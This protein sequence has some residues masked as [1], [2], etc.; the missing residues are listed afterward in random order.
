MADLL[1]SIPDTSA[2]ED[3]EP[4][5]VGLE[6]DD[7]DDLLAALSSTTARKLFAE[8]NDEPNTPSKLADRVD[9]TLQ[10]AQY[11]LEKLEDADLIEVVDTAYSEKGREMDVYAPTDKP[12]VVFAG[13]EDES[14]TLKKALSRL[15]GGLGVLAIASLV[16]DRLVGT[17]LSTGGGSGGSSQGEGAD[18]GTPLADGTEDDRAG[19]A[20]DDYGAQGEN[21]TDDNGT[22]QNTSAGNESSTDLSG[23]KSEELAMPADQSDATTFDLHLP[24]DIDIVGLPPG[25]LFFA[26]GAL[27]LACTFAVWYWQASR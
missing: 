15:L 10:N 1:P 18:G 5:V 3:R 24:G 2:A 16:V 21:M 26:G 13:S 4:R 9:T 6:S 20:G 19:G 14:S 27:M 12:L 7:A 22:A 11:H 23:T 25:V 17:D 8:L